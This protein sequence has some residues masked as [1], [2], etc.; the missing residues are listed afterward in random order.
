M[1][2]NFS[3]LTVSGLGSNLTQMDEPDAS[4]HQKN[5]SSTETIHELCSIVTPENKETES[6]SINNHNLH[7]KL[8]KLNDAY[9]NYVGVVLELSGLIKNEYL[10]TWYSLDQPL[11]PSLFKELEACLHPELEDNEEVADGSCDHQLLFDLINDTLVDIYERSFTYFPKAFS[12]N[13]HIRPMPKG[14]QLHEEVWTKINSYLSLRPELDQSL[15]DVVARDLV[16]CDGWM[17][18]QFDSEC[19]AL[20]LE[21]VILEEL[22]DELVGACG[23]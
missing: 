7:S 8:D 11:S 19:V 10:G 17:N 1:A 21:D 2:N 5:R 18:L 22:L 20:E 14:H 6:T 15:E 4:V 9:F 16:K 12:F 13:R 23:C 3:L